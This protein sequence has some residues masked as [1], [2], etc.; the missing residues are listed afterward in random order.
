MQ[1]GI[2]GINHKLADL[3]LRELLAKIC[4]KWFGTGACLHGDHVFLLLSTCNRTEIY[5]SSE[6]LA[7]THIYILGILRLEIEEEFDHKLYSYFGIDCF[8]H[9][10]R[11]TAGLD[12]AVVA[13]T[14]IQGQVKTAYEQAAGQRK[15]PHDLHFMFQKSLKIGRQL[16]TQIPM[17]RGVPDVEH[18]ILSVGSRFFKSCIDAKILFVGASEINQK[19]I[20]HFLFKQMSNIT[21]C[22]R[23]KSNLEKI[24]GMHSIKVLEWENLSAWNNYDWIILGTK[25]PEFLISKKDIQEIGHSQSKLM[26]DLSVPRNVDPAI[27]GKNSA[28][29]L[30]NIDQINQLLDVRKEQMNHMLVQAE[31]LARDS[32]QK[33]IA[34]FRKSKEHCHQESLDEQSLLNPLIV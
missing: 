32:T 19:I 10:S 21:I 11:V 31:R 16:R 23:S 5:F 34:L 29:T 9:L 8:L 4:Q 14:E 6:D 22:N 1:V 13:E 18:A 30:L 33:Q 3:K 15:L 2:I 17:G 12:S 25:C 7:S 27:A 26:I 20:S 28:I 24:A